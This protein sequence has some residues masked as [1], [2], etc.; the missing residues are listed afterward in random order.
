MSEIEELESL[1]HEDLCE[2]TLGTLTRLLKAD[3]LLSDLPAGVTSE[4]VNSQ[5]AVA[6]G[7]SITL[8]ILRNLEPSLHVVVPQGKSTVL[9]L[10]KAIKRTFELRQQ[11]NRS[12]GKISWRYIW[13]TYRLNFN[14]VPLTKDHSLLSLYGIKN[15]SQ[16]CFV[17]R[18]RNRNIDSD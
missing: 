1:S 18:L 9:D 15:K 13:R 3:C 8:E 14:G 5:I 2:I 4:E 17:K 12:R 16:L 10:K 11:R 7:Q 6:Q